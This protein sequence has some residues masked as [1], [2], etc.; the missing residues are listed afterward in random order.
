MLLTSPPR[1]SS[2]RRS[3][4]LAEVLEDAASD[5]LVLNYR[6]QAHQPGAPRA[7]EHLHLVRPL[8]GNSPRQSS[9][10][11]RVVGTYD[12]ITPRINRVVGG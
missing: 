6:A 1:P 8:H 9:L 7:D 4:G 11:A 12:V 5:A 2:W 10:P 3:C